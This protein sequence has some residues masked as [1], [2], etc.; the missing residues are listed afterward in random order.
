M[1]AVIFGLSLSLFTL[2]VAANPSFFFRKTLNDAVA[3]TTRSLFSSPGTATTSLIFDAYS[4]GSNLA[5][6]LDSAYL[7][8]QMTASS[9]A[10]VLRITTESAYGSTTVDCLATPL[11]CDWYKNNNYNLVA[12]TTPEIT[13]LNDGSIQWTFASSTQGMQAN[14]NS[15]LARKGFPILT[16][17]RYTRVIFTHPMG[18]SNFF[19]YAELI[20]KKQE[21]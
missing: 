11:K 21:K 15:N 18:A 16:P 20:G 9:T 10:S 19:L 4:T 13:Y 8:V 2:E 7:Q 17:T 5:Y 1:I 14:H 12:S 3:T 6:G